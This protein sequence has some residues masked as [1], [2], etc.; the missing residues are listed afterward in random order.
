M[1]AENNDKAP[2]SQEPN[3]PDCDPFRIFELV[4]GKDFGG[5]E[6]EPD[7]ASTDQERE[8]DLVQVFP[9]ERIIPAPENRLIY[10]P[11]SADDPE[12]I[13]LAKS[14]KAIGVQEPLIISSDFYLI[15]GHRRRL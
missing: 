14:I 9:V 15:S 12:V 2:S 13:A 4:F 11:V 6:A 8:L 10:D 7:P 5:V 1:L 3:F